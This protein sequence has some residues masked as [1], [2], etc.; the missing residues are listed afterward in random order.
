MIL[1]LMDRHYARSD[2]TVTGW[3]DE[4]AGVEQLLQVGDAPALVVVAL[5][6]AAKIV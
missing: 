1:H 4:G 2:G 5:W 6:L 3:R